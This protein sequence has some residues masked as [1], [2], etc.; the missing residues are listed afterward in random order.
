V[1]GWHWVAQTY[2]IELADDMYKLPL[3]SGKI[4]KLSTKSHYPE[5]GDSIFHRHFG[6]NLKP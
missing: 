1:K 3:K 5:D 6:T 2:T 4:K